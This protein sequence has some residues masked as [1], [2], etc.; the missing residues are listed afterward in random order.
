MEGGG[1]HCIKRRRRAALYRGREESTIVWREEG[2]QQ[3]MKGEKRAPLYK[4]RK[5]STTM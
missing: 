5:E 3:C 4:G 2:E 1:Q